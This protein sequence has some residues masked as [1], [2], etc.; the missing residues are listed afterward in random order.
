MVYLVVSSW[1]GV[2]R[3]TGQ[4]VNRSTINRSKVGFNRSVGEVYPIKGELQL[5]TYM[6][7]HKKRLEW[8]MD[9]M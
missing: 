1:F 4:Q 9:C 5:F 7:S 8:H 2:Q 3:S 6:R